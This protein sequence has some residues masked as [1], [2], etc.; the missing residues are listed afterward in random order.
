[1]AEIT[2]DDLAKCHMELTMRGHGT[3]FFFSRFRC[4]EHPRLSRHDHYEKKSRSVKSIFMVDGADVTDLAAAIVALNKPVEISDKDR[5]V[6]ERV[7]L[8]W[9]DLRKKVGFMDMHALADKGLVEFQNGKCRR[10]VKR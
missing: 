10:V 1:M 6:L 2:K 8:D 9:T 5:E 3:G 4:V 7:P